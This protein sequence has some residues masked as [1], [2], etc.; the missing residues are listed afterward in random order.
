MYIQ[1]QTRMQSPSPKQKVVVIVVVIVHHH[2][3]T[4]RDIINLGK[5]S[6]QVRPFNV[7]KKERGADEKCTAGQH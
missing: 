2:Q 3:P 4:P 6:T 7:G 5:S 1:L